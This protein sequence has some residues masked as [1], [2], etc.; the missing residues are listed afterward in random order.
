MRNSS[1]R[2]GLVIGCGGTLGA[3]WTVGALVA[4]RDALDW[5][6]RSAEV[7]VGTSAGSELVTMLGAGVGVDELLAAQL[8]QAGARPALAEHVAAHPPMMPPVPTARIGSPRLAA[9][10]LTGKVSR[11]TALAAALPIGR[12]DAAWLADVVDALVPNRG[13]V[14]HP[15]TWVVA[16]DLATGERVAFGSP[17]APEVPLRDAV[18]ASWAVPGWFSPVTL[19]GRRFADG[20]MVSPASADLV[21]PLEL[22]EV[23]VLAPMTSIEPGRATGLSR[24]ERL[25]RRAMTRTLDAEVEAL[26]AAGSKVL[27]LDPGEQDLI[28]FGPNVMDHRR[29]LGVLRT[30]L[31]TAPVAVRQALNDQGIAARTE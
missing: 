3:A 26:R 13:W 27:R 24:A 23:V 11:L 20:G 22:D 6:P 5:D 17:E 28:A 16:A 29:R 2:R 31:R 18:R 19:H 4:V 14:D 12:G 15:A 7:L 25:L 30:A 8:G 10:G 21:L 9:R 1:P